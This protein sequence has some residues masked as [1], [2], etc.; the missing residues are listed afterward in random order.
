MDEYSS[1]KMANFSK[2]AIN[3][4][5]LRFGWKKVIASAVLPIGS[6]VNCQIF[7]G[8][9]CSMSSPGGKRS[10]LMPTWGPE[11]MPALLTS[12]LPTELHTSWQSLTRSQ[13]ELPQKQPGMSS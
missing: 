10:E 5:T 1:A 2:T 9:I 13:T 8:Y 3:S 11:A 12:A 7:H 4:A 6:D